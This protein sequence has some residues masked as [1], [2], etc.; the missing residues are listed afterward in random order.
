MRNIKLVIQYDGSRYKGFQAQKDNDLTVQGKIEAVL[1]KMSSENITIIGC[2]R[3]DV[4][5]HAEN[6]VANFQTEC[7][8]SE[9]MMLDYLYEFLPED[10]VVKSVEEVGERFHARYN[11]KSKTYRYT[12]NNKSIRNVF[13]RKYVYH[14]EETLD[15]E[16]MRQAAEVLMGT[17]DYQSFTSLKANGKSTVRTINLIDIETKDGMIIIEVNANDFLWHMPRLIIGALL[18]VGL[19]EKSVEDLSRRLEACKKPEFE[20][21]AKAKGLCLQEVYY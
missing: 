21:M 1:S 14:L 5:V 9:K 19:G 18:E 4:G 16:N 15:I 17:H 10:I 11:V 8:L 20:M 6:Y 13:E 7:E 2:E 12:I 3:T